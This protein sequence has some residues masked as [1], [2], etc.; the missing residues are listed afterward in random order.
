[1]TQDALL[2]DFNKGEIKYVKVL[3]K[4]I[5]NEKN[6]FKELHP[7]LES[8]LNTTPKV[9]YP[10]VNEDVFE[11]LVC[12]LYNSLHPQTH[13]ERFGKKGDNQKGIDVYSVITK[14]AIQCKK[15]DLSR[16]D[17][18]IK[19]EL[20]NDFKSD[21]LKAMTLEMEIELL[22]FTSTYKN[23]AGL[24]EYLQG[25]KRK[26]RPKF[27]VMYVGWDSL[28]GRIHQ[29]PHLINKY[30]PKRLNDARSDWRCLCGGPAQ[31]RACAERS[32][33]ASLGQISPPIQKP[34][35]K[36]ALIKKL[37]TTTHAV[38]THDSP[39]TCCSNERAKHAT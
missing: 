33:E 13:F 36:G 28:S 17:S 3:K 12:D 19:R 31:R 23:N 24:E 9:Q 27:E 7:F 14:E 39:T 1:M 38:C 37:Q 15:K 25:L 8:Q 4:W 11:D 6:Y 22:I 29:F 20:R 35:K 18:N 10:P 21:I 30:F 2:M 34:P 32:E 5:T 26:L 16:P